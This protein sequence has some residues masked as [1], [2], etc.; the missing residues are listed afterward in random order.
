MRRPR[1]P[2]CS[3]LTGS[4][5]ARDRAAGV[6]PRRRPR[7]ARRTRCRRHLPP[8]A[9]PPP[10]DDRARPDVT[11]E[12]TNKAVRRVADTDERADRAQAV[13][14][15]RAATSSEAH[16]FATGKG[17]KIAIID[18]GVDPSNPRFSGPRR[19]RRRLRR[20]PT[21]T[22]PTTAT[23][24]APRSP[25]SP[26]RSQ[27]RGRL[28]RRRTGRDDPGDPPD[29]RP[30][31]VQGRRGQHRAARVGR[32]GGTLAQAIVRAADQGAKVDQHLVDE[33]RLPQGLRARTT[34]RCRPPSSTRSTTRTS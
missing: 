10:K 11:Y 16:R 2:D 17:V 26:R 18:T 34:G 7:R 8:A 4:A 22:A 28:R 30:L 23:A 3:L 13:G 32:Q 14:P 20:R 27:D 25:A 12:R 6:A 9:P 15:G 29:Q 21:R 5:A 1:P 33:L 31:R 19:G 24:T